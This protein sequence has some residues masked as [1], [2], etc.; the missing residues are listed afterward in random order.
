MPT[1]ASIPP[2]PLLPSETAPR[3]QNLARTLASEIESGRY[4][5]GSKLP[6]EMD[7]CTQ[8]GAGRHTVRMALD[9]LVRAGLIKRTPRLGTLVIATKPRRGYQLSVSQISDLTQFSANTQMEVLE[10]TVQTVT[11]KANDC[12][13]AYQGQQWLFVSGL[14][15]SSDYDVPISYHEVWVHPDYRSIAGVQ[16]RIKQSIFDLIEQQFGVAATRVKQT[17][18]SA[19]PDQKMEALLKIEPNTPCLW[20]HREYYDSQSRLVELSLS[21]HPGDLFSYEM[22]LERSIPTSS[23]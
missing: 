11:D 14:R 6:R 10:R 3:H 1:K 8:F 18:R 16:G 17:I 23:S 5:V 21:V 20:V 7:L 4:P 2:N 13:A 19:I 15:H 22:E 12:L 9:R